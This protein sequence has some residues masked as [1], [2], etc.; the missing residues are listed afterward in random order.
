MQFPFTM[1]VS[2]DSIHHGLPLAYWSLLRVLPV[3]SSRNARWCVLFT[4]KWHLTPLQAITQ[5]SMD[6]WA[7]FSFTA[8][9]CLYSSEHRTSRAVSTGC[10]RRH[11]PLFQTN[12]KSGLQKALCSLPLLLLAV[13]KLKL[14]H[15]KKKN[16]RKIQDK[17]PPWRSFLFQQNII[18]GRLRDN[19]QSLE[20]D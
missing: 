7:T 2:T 12:G 9:Q 14:Q 16:K 13:T 18:Q 15:W 17:L 11:A 8:L 4:P 20:L 3:T 10:C 19:I 6:E 1:H 5:C